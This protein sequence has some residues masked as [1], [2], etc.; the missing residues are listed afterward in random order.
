MD[1][2]ANLSLGTPGMPGAD[3]PTMVPKPIR[4]VSEIF[5]VCGEKKKLS[6][7]V[8]ITKAVGISPEC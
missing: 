5:D 8:N 1:P 7:D 3:S 2:Y 4:S 6:N